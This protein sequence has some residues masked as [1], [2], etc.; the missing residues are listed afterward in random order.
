MDVEQGETEDRTV[1][2]DQWQE[3]SKRLVKGGGGLFKEYFNELNQ[4]GNDQDEHDGLEEAQPHED[5]Q[6]VEQPCD[7]ARQNHDE[8]NGQGHADC[9][10]Y[11]F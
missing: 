4:G 6:S 10:V 8:Y 2:R 11:L 7:D 5:E 3:Y 9:R 1:C